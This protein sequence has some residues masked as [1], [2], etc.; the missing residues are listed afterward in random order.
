MRMGSSQR[1]LS[2]HKRIVITGV[3]VICSLGAGAS[4]MWE[5]ACRGEVRLVQEKFRMFNGRSRRFFF[6]KAIELGLAELGIDGETQDMLDSWKHGRVD[7]DLYWAI[8]AARQAVRDSKLKYDPEDNDVSLFLTHENPGLEL[9]F[10]RTVRKSYTLLSRV[11]GAARL[12]R[13]EYFKQIYRSCI[14]DGYDAQTFMYLYL[15]ARALGVHG[16]TAFNCNACASGLYAL[17]AAARELRQGTSSAAIVVGSDHPQLIYKFLWFEDQNLYA[18][19]GLTRPFDKQRQGFA[20]GEAASALVVEELES[21]KARGAPIYAE[22]LGGGFRFQGWK[23]TI[24]DPTSSVYGK[25]MTSALACAGLSPQDINL[26]NAH[27]VGTVV[28][29][30]YEARAIRGVFGPPERQ[31][32][33][34]GFKP[35]LGHTL[36]GCALL[37]LILTLLCMRHSV[38]LP[39]Q[40]YTEPDPTLEL[41]VA[42]QLE[43]RKLRYV[44]KSASGFAGYDASA[45]FAR[46]E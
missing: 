46:V 12:D 42:D 32:P 34:V 38:I 33:V 30:A 8:G 36:G 6:H 1:H 31:P 45:I 3:G 5:A 37:E 24:P 14:D 44:M 28:G 2:N 17:E 29:D 41:R 43:H 10:D 40:N 23:V 19:D 15:V 4:R 35:Y 9:F 20:I 26:L 25:T 27:G 22:Y 11:N 16:Y 21:A 7:E 13:G 18:P 39:T